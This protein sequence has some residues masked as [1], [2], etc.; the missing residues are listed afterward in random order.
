MENGLFSEWLPRYRH[1]LRMRNYSE[2][3]IES[4][5]EIVDRFARYIWLRRHSK[6]GKLIFYWKD[7]AL[8]R[9]DTEVGV[10]VPLVTDFLSFLS[11]L[12]TYRHRTLPRTIST[13]SSTWGQYATL[14]PITYLA[15]QWLK[16]N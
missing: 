8:A 3:T 14:H 16:H 13:L 4:Y 15:N 1:Y 5:E 11:S 2:R 7:L 10:S 12:R 6:P 9:I